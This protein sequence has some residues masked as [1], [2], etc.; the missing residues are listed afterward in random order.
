MALERP[1]QD[2][3]SNFMVHGVIPIVRNWK[4][5]SLFA[6]FLAGELNN[7]QNTRMNE[8]KGLIVL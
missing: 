3:C 5:I 2:N 6:F 1:I 7:S 4:S 8:E